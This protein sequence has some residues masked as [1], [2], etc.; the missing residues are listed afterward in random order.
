MMK[1]VFLLLMLLLPACNQA[2]VTEITP[3]I[4]YDESEEL[5]QNADHQSPKMRYKLIQSKNLDKNAI[6]ENVAGQIRNFSEEDYQRLKPL[7]LEQDI[8]AIQSHILSGE[9]SYEKL[10]Q[11]YLYRIVK[12]ENDRNTTLNNIIAINPDAVSE[13]R[14]RDKNRSA[15]DHPIYGMPI[16]LKDNVG[17]EGLPTTAG[18]SALLNNNTPDAFIVERIKEKGGIILGKTN[19]SE[20]ANYLSSA[21]PNGYSAVGGQTLNPYG[22]RKFDTGGSSSGSGTSMAANYAAAA[23]GTE[24]SGSILSPSSASSIAGLKPT[25]GLLSRSG[26]VPLSGTLDTPGPM[27][28]NVTDNAI[29]LSAMCGE[30]SSDNA[31]KNNPKNVK[32]WEELGTA[33]MEGLRF[34]VSND[35]LKDSLFMLTVDKIVS[36]GG[37]AIEFE[38]EKIRLDG[39]GTLLS[40]D[41]KADLPAYLDKYAS[42]NIEIR[43]VKEI[44]DYN[45]ADTLVRI[46]YG[47]TIFEEIIKLEIS[48]EELLQLK[49]KLHADAVS[50]FEK[51]MTE[52]QLDAILSVNNRNAGNAA[53]AFYPC[54]TVPMGYRNTGAPAG[55]TFIVRPFE[56]DKL[57]RI[58]YAF[59]QGTKMR[60]L[61][62]AYK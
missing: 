19:L 18:A 4:P 28:R 51:P 40:A 48:P 6:W 25:V 24:T 5:A 9:L 2:P 54:L 13:A 44:A 1:N 7:I 38:P 11:W 16:M 45:M 59:E 49:T 56:E 31:T 50:Y 14:E 37:I 20:W 10:T 23:V 21:C 52:Y 41:M 55:I 62:E 33:S 34:G 60:Q 43:S 61:P 35:L 15:G 26:I 12:F 57:L 39:F 32:Y 17:M 47:Q 42:D 22:R 58:G 30:D 29:L 27:T 53:A 8:P 36:L 3:W 46:P